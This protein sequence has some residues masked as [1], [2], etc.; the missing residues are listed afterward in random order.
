MM[1]NILKT[2]LLFTLLLLVGC[3]SKQPN[4]DAKYEQN[5]LYTKVGKVIQNNEV[6]MLLYVTYLNSAKKE[7][8]SDIYQNFLV[9]VYSKNNIQL[10]S[11]KF[12]MNNR[13]LFYIKK[14]D[15]T[16]SLYKD[17]ALR[18]S[19]SDY[20]IIKFYNTKKKYLNLDYFYDDKNIIKIRFKKE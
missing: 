10:D 7:K 12:K 4:P 15:K 16:S 9:S 1:K 18:N 17:I 13:D 11:E 8:Y 14:I 5:L 2:T 3:G 20:Y 6:K 19:W